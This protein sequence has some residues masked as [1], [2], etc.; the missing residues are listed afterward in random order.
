VPI[1]NISESWEQKKIISLGLMVLPNLGIIFWLGFGM[2]STK[3][4]GA[5]AA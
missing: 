2:R 3:A 4:L 1:S 5:L